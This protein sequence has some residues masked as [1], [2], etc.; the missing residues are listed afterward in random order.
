VR[1]LAQ[2]GASRGPDTRDKEQ[3]TA[4][5]LAR[6]TYGIWPCHHAY[7]EYRIMY[8]WDGAIREAEHD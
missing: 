5:N 2:L 8:G 6:I 1:I 7:I 3:S 4:L